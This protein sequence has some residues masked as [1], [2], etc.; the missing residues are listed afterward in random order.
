MKQPRRRWA[1]AC[2]AI[3][4][5]V[6][7]Q[8]GPAV[9][10]ELEPVPL[11]LAI[12]DVQRI[13]QSAAA[14]N[15]LQ[16]RM[17][18]YLEAYRTETQKEEEGIRAAQ[19]ELASKR[20]V[21]TQEQY[22]AERR[23]LEQRLVEAQAKVQQRKQGLDQTQQ[24]GMNVVQSTLNA[25]VTEIA[26]EKDLT[27]ILRKDQTVLNAT[28]LE[29]TDLVLNRLNERLPTVEVANPGSGPGTD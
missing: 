10:A 29:I 3:V 28:A 1:A 8:I 6:S 15:A 19:Q 11:R 27:L 7:M 12:L 14:V 26:N 24:D 25:V 21:I 23:S 5:A 4:L 18:E 16:L 17:R 9:P 20:D 2:I 13:F 22:E